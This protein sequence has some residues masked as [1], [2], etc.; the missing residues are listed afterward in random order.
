[1]RSR[2][3]SAAREETEVARLTRE[4]NEAFQ[5]QSATADVLK[6]ISGSAFDLKL[7]LHVLIESATR[8]CGATRGHILRFNGE[9]LTLAAAHNA[10]PGFTEY[11]EAHP[12]RKEP[13]LSVGQ[14][15]S[16]TFYK[17]PATSLAI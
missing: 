8:L 15:M 5:Q 12:F 1:M 6:V 9:L 16:M 14:F 13:R 10:W 3:S 7:V 11:L 17:N 2:N 4:L